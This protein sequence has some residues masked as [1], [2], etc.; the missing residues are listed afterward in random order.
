MDLL[1]HCK[2]E[3][4]HAVWKIILGDEF[5]GS[6]R[7]SI[8]IK[9]H[10]GVL[11]RVYPQIFTY[12]A[13][14]PEKYVEYSCLVSEPVPLMNSDTGG[15]KCEGLST[16]GGGDAEVLRTLASA[17]VLRPCDTCV[18]V[19]WRT[20]RQSD[21]GL[22]KVGVARRQRRTEENRG[23]FAGSIQDDIRTEGQSPQ[24]AE[25]L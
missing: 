23:E 24:R 8:V 16:T 21:G 20:K 9:C 19:F 6:Y 5:I 12:S 2:H 15:V 4:F 18:L 1:T 13:D 3:L 22:T 7:N 25:Y 11:R 17:Y 10:D 14:Y